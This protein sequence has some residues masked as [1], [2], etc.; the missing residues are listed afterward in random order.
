MRQL[1]L[2]CAALVA[3]CRPSVSVAMCGVGWWGW[4]V[5]RVGRC[6][7][8]LGSGCMP[9]VCCTM[10]EAGCSLFGSGWVTCKP[11]IGCTLCGVVRLGGL[12]TCISWDQGAGCQGDMEA[13]STLRNVWAE[14][15]ASPIEVTRWGYFVAS[16]GSWRK[17]SASQATCALVCG[18]W[19]TNDCKKLEG[20]KVSC[21]G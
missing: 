6:L 17:P 14:L 4:L 2:L 5:G 8:V 18:G 10:R 9:S 19:A 12:V 3:V 16:G 1:L 7:R 15:A 20:C 21:V 11:C 13:V